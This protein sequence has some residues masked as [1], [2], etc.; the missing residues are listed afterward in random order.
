MDGKVPRYSSG[1]RPAEVKARSRRYSWQGARRR[2]SG[3]IS[4]IRA[5]VVACY[6]AEQREIPLDAA[7]AIVR[8]ERPRTQID[9]ALLALVEHQWPPPGAGV[10]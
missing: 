9:R 3:A 1:S 8:R 5:L 7:V 10:S 2:S 4:I 6:L